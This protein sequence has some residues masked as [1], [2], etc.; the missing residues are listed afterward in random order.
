MQ[1]ANQTLTCG[2]QDVAVFG[3]H[4]ESM[5]IVEKHFFMIYSFPVAAPPA[6]LGRCSHQ[7]GGADLQ[8]GDLCHL[9]GGDAPCY[10]RQC[11]GLPWTSLDVLADQSVD[12]N[13]LFPWLRFN[14]ACTVMPASLGSVHAVRR[15][16]FQDHLS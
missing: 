4:H 6:Q 5:S 12:L 11:P 10:K 2:A 7:R 16:E 13:L 1:A 3:D 14:H 9:S 8:R 15:F